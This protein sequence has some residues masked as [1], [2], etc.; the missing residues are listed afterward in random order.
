MYLIIEEM[1]GMS[2]T[3]VVK[4]YD[5]KDLPFK[6]TFDLD[7]G[8]GVM[9]YSDEEENTVYVIDITRVPKKPTRTTYTLYCWNCAHAHKM[10]NTKWASINCRNQ[11][12]G[13]I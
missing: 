3:E 4:S 10:T 1:F 13:I 11:D 2:E 6:P 5:E 12:R 8:N 9:F 7:L